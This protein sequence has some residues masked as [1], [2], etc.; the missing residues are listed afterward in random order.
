M[1]LIFLKLELN[2]AKA[3]RSLSV[4]RL[5]LNVM[6]YIKVMK[7]KS[8]TQLPQRICLTQ[9]SLLSE[10]E[11]YD[12]VKKPPI[13]GIFLCPDNYVFEI[14]F[15]PQ[16]ARKFCLELKGKR[17]YGWG[18]DEQPVYLTHAK[19]QKLGQVI[20]IFYILTNKRAVSY[21]IVVGKPLLRFEHCIL[22][23]FITL[24]QNFG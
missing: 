14:D 17:V 18:T 10:F 20:L 1:L 13:T 21:L 4:N 23:P 19:S 7:Y 6:T 11:L 3:N 12:P 22:F 16:N 8:K 2:F 9:I 15:S 5:L 24:C